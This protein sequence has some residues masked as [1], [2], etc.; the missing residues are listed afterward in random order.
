MAGVVHD[1]VDVLT[2]TGLDA[3]KWLKWWILCY[4]NVISYTHKFNELVSS[5]LA[6]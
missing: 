4:V 5:V 1:N 3:V 6:I 2:T